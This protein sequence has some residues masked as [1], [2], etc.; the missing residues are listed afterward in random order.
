[1]KVK[2]FLAISMLLSGLMLSACGKQA[3]PED[4]PVEIDTTIPA[5]ALGSYDITVWGS[6]VEGVEALFKKQI[7]DFCELN[8]G[9]T[10]NVTYEQVS[11]AKAGAEVLKDI[12]AAGD[13]FCFAQDQ[14]ADLVQGQ[15]LTRLGNIAATAVKANNDAGSVAA[16]TSGEALYAYPMTAD[17][18]Y[19]MYYDTRVVKA[20][21]LGSLEDIVADCEAAGRN[22]AMET[23]TSAW[24]LASFFFGAGCVSE[25]TTNAEGDFTNVNDTFNSANGIKALRGM[26]HL[27]KSQ[28]YISASSVEQFSAA[29]PAGVVVSGTWDYEKAVQTLGENLGIAQLPSY[30]VDG[31]SYHLGSFSGFKLVGVKP[32]TNVKRARVL[33]TLALYLTGQKCQEERFDAVKWG[34]SNR[35][36]AKMDKVQSN[37]ALAALLAQSAY[38]RPQGAIPGAWWDFAKTLGTVALNAAND[39]TAALQEGLTAYAA[40]ID[41]V[42]HPTETPKLG[43]V[44]AFAGNDTSWNS[45]TAIAM[46]ERDG[47]WSISTA[48]AA[49]DEFK[50]VMFTSSG[51]NWGSH[52]MGFSKLSA[53]SPAYAAFADNGG[54]IKVVTAGRYTFTAT[55]GTDDVLSVRSVD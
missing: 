43:L 50:V 24:Y 9:L 31:E 42:V 40:A 5:E 46:E 25:W 12:D 29:T 18:G 44:G 21:H 38:S 14:F 17:N 22:F 41:N 26:Q 10:L 2:K 33:S 34:P 16:V 1:M 48:L 30:K 35:F 13:I 55:L 53:D 54:N 11:E 20:N 28:N 39:D 36:V 37:P 45:A 15:A 3:E 7:Q 52:E 4:K 23:S 49:G 27:V 6:E 32:T 47:V 19:F 8:P 51:V